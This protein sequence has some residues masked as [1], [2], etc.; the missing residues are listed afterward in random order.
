ANLAAGG[1]G[2][3]TGNPPGTNLDSGT[4]ASAGNF[5]GGDGGGVRPPLNGIADPGGDR[6][7]R[8]WK[9][10]LAL[11]FGNVSSTTFSE[12]YIALTGS[13]S[14]NQHSVVDATG[15]TNTGAL[16]EINTVGTST[17]I[18]FQVTAQGT[19]NGIKVDT[20]G[21]ARALGSGGVDASALVTGT[22]ANARFPSAAQF[23]A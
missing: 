16:F 2:G 23:A 19:T 6:L 15:N 10:K 12:S 20:G 7:F 21:I 9:K 13:P 5:W 4:N 14:V 11:S 22:V 1:K 3:G 17:A 18:P 8:F